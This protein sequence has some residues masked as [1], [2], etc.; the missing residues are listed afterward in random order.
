MTESS[1]H[2]VAQ[3]TTNNNRE[4]IT[5]ISEEEQKKQQL[6]ITVEPETEQ[7]LKRLNH[8]VRFFLSNKFFIEERQS[9]HSSGDKS[10]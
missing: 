4:A 5:Q 2:K 1:D 8:D 7:W 3:N 9:E 6:E 10:W